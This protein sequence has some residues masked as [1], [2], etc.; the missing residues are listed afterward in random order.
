M[1]RGQPSYGLFPP[2]PTTFLYLEVDGK[3]ELICGQTRVP[4]GAAQNSQGHKFRG[5]L[6]TGVYKTALAV[7]KRVS[8]A[9]YWPRYGPEYET[10]R[11]MM[12]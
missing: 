2:P 7:K 9:M 3:R 1:S 8:C 10:K 5:L 4:F 11:L 6:S 12:I